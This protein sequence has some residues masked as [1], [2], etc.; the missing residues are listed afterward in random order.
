[1]CF[2]VTV[3]TFQF[4]GKIY[5][6]E[7]C[8]DGGCKCEGRFLD[9]VNYMTVHKFFPCKKNKEWVQKIVITL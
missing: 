5:G 4:V 7:A 1:M 3:T 6:W 2:F 9:V 8:F